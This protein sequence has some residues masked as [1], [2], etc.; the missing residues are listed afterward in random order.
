[1]FNLNANVLMVEYRG[2]GESKPEHVKPSESGI[3]TDCEAVLQFISNHDSVDPSRIFI[4]G[5][6]LGGSV[7]F[8]VAQFAEKNDIKLSGI[9]IENAFISVSRMVDVVLPLLSPLKWLI[10]RINYDSGKLAPKLKVPILYLSGD[11]DEIVPH[12]HMKELYAKS[13]ESS[14]D[15]RMYVV[16]GGT[17]N[18]TWLQGGKPYWNK[19][20]E[21]L[22]KEKTA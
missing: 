15:A 14:V 7:A 4:F 9:I 3:K 19:I 6:S 1:M 11:A 2:Y 12:S 13:L 5:R 21:F 16:K 10:L 22:F 17:H 8:H 18:E 20:R